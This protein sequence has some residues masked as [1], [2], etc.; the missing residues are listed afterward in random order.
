MVRRGFVAAAFAAVVLVPAAAA[1]SASQVQLALVPLPKSTLGPAGHSLPLARDS[2]VVSNAEAASEATASVTAAQLTRLGRVSGYLL[3]YGNPFGGAAGVTEIQTAIERYRNA[4]DARKG[5]DFWRR[6]E[7]NSSSL[8]K[9]GID[10]SVKALRP[11]GIPGPHWVYAGTATI[12]GLKPIHGVDAEFEQGQYLLDVSVSAGSTSAA[13]QLVPTVARRLYQRMRLALAG[14]LH[15]SPVKLPRPLQPGPPAHGP[16]PAGLVLTTAD[17]GSRATV[18]RNTYSKPKDALDQNALSVYDLTMTSSGTFPFLSQEV[19]VGGTQTEVRYFAAIAVSALAAGFGGKAHV[20][21]V[22][23]SGVGDNARGE[24][25]KVAVNGR[26]AYEAVVVLSR[27][28]YLDFLVGASSSPFT[29]A[30][31]RNLAQLAAKRL[32]AGF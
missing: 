10:F 30:E 24:L 12:K 3:D 15:A 22:S 11:S 21:P 4:A 23:L 13:A 17:L 2:G 18:V 28:S 32:D 9:L 6:D 7:L 5:L 14:R 25:V 19:L 20:T 27:G 8:K 31:V 26:T 1:S 29:A 16:K